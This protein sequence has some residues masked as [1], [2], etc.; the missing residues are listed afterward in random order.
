MSNLEKY[1][2][3]NYETHVVPNFNIQIYPTD[4]A[5]VYG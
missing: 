1:K 2:E 3:G 5:S 4:Y